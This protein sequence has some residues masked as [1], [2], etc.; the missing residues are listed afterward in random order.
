MTGQ[1]RRRFAR[2]V[3]TGGGSATSPV[4]GDVEPPA[5]PAAHAVTL[6]VAAQP[7]WN[8]AP[9]AAA[10]PATADVGPALSLDELMPAHLSPVLTRRLRRAR[11]NRRL[12]MVGAAV[13]GLLAVGGIAALAL[14][15]DGSPSAAPV[16][17]QKA[18][19]TTTVRRATTTSIGDPSGT[20]SP[21][22]SSPLS[23]GG[24][25]ANVA[26]PPPITAPGAADS[27][28]SD[29][30]VTATQ[31]PGTCRWADGDLSVAGTLTNPGTDT[32]TA[33]VDVSWRDATG[34]L[35]SSSDQQTVPAGGSARWSAQGIDFVSDPPQG[36]VTCQ[37]SVA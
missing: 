5:E 37:V 29:P 24:S 27:S 8:P 35:G 15:D 1:I 30:V 4:A 9:I 10:I 34:E 20:Q 32:V 36:D 14:P 23:S 6:P 25:D 11:R 3:P 28:A 26:I 31:D 33:W 21:S 19:T 7:P 17:G 16:R 22:T 13:A 18:P 2:G 12:A